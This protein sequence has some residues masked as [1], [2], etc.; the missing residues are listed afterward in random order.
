MP[1]FANLEDTLT[2][3]LTLARRPVAIAFRDTAPD[4]VEPFVGEEPSGCSFWRLAAA[5][6]VFYTVPSD[7]YNCS[8]GSYTHNIPLP[9]AREPELM[10]TLS[11][12]SDAGYIRMGELPSIPRLPKTPAFT[13]YAPLAASPVDPDV[14]VLSGK[15][16]RT[17]LLHEAALRGA[18]KMLPMLGR[19]T[20][21][22]IPAALDGGVAPSL[23]CVGNRI[24]T[25]ATDDEY[26]IV[27]AARDLPRIVEQMA[28]V[29]S[30]NATLAKYHRERREAL[31]TA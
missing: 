13:I 16:G 19:P 25:D 1:D 27:I 5:G 15:P 2:S 22:A 17:L 7:H 31:A 20:C 3:V 14:V 28:T 12:M 29:V 30:A 23:G 8:I 4:G 21:M 6:R 24:Y 9:P 10:Q 18:T 11:L 26:Y